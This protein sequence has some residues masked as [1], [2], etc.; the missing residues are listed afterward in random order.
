MDVTTAQ[1]HLNAWLAADLAVSKGQSYSVGNRSLS[2]SDAETIRQ[3]IIYWTRIVNTLTAQAAA[4]SGELA[5][6]NPGV[7][8]ASWS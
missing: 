8:L 3:Q 5:A 2:R 4:T 1:T 7:A 6:T